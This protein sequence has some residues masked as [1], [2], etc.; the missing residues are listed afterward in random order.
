[1]RS[2]ILFHAT[3]FD[4][5]KEYDHLFEKKTERIRNELEK[6]GFKMISHSYYRN[7]AISVFP[8]DNLSKIVFSVTANGVDDEFTITYDKENYDEEVF[9]LLKDFFSVPKK[10][11]W[12]LQD[13]ESGVWRTDCE[14]MH[15][16]REGTP[17]DNGMAYCCY[18]GRRVE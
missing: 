16:L 2:L 3:L 1:M 12:N 4:F 8:L 10:C 5:T 14:H 6:R 15:I 18:C 11:G 13:D 7:L 17:D 9:A